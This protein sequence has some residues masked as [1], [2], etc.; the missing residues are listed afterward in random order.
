MTLIYDQI[1]QKAVKLA[2]QY[3]RLEFELMEAISEVDRQGVYKELGYTSL[4][5]YCTKALGLSESCAY[6]FI[7]VERKARQVPELQKAIKEGDL[8]ISQG[9][10]ILA[11][12]PTDQTPESAKSAQQWINRARDLTQRQIER[13]IATVNPKEAVKESMRYIQEQRVALKCG[14]SEELMKKIERIKDIVSQKRSVPSSLEMALEE[15]AKTYLERNDVRQAKRERSLWD[16][17][18]TIQK[19][20]RQG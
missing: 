15:M 20:S 12:L 19:L 10:R 14:I 4:F 17:R 11:V 7:S 13:E 5:S 2:A 8:S 9:K 16:E 1:H 6:A 18:S 3:R